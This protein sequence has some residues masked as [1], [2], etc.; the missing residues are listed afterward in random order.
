MLTIYDKDDEQDQPILDNH[1][2]DIAP[3]ALVPH[4]SQM[5]SQ[6]WSDILEL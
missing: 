3:Q 4:D 6:F 5:L 2:E 1:E